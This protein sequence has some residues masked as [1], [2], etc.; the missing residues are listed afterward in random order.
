MIR[1][2]L[3]KWRI[4]KLPYTDRF[5]T[6]LPS[7][8]IGCGMLHEGNVYLMDYAIKNMPEG[9]YVLEIGSWA[10]LST[11]LLLHL[12]EK[13]GR[14]EQFLGCDPWLYSYNDAEAEQEFSIDGKAEVSRAEYMDYI[15]QGFIQAALLFH[16]NKLPHTFRLKSD[17]FFEQFSQK[18]MVT[19]VFGRST[20][21]DGPISFCYIDGNHAYEYVKR[22]FENVN[23]HLMVNGMILFDDSFIGSGFGSER[24]LLEI[25][26][27]PNFKVL[28]RNPNY[29][30]QK[31]A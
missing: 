1:R 16:K 17:D 25:K 24:L 18:S 22:D 31:L 10:G 12:M 30:I 15:R 6:R 20:Q 11:N 27:D 21:L 4:K 7:S 9:K 28:D 3:N 13:Y 19:D 2:L 29:L 23:Q 26:Q 5:I 14:K 8:T